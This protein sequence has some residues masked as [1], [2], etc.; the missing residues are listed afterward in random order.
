MP[1]HLA[2]LSPFSMP[3]A[4]LADLYLVKLVKEL[5]GFK[6]PEAVALAREM[7][8]SHDGPESLVAL[9]E[10]LIADEQHQEAFDEYRAEVGMNGEGN[11]PSRPCPL[12]GEPVASNY[13]AC[14]GYQVTTCSIDCMRRHRR[15]KVSE[16]CLP[17][18]SLLTEY[19]KSVVACFV[20]HAS[21]KDL[22]G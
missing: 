2:H 19:Q 1:K 18:T 11:A 9:S 20:K 4:V 5:S 16:K 12:C 22:A 8:A 6:P 15:A 21:T 17:K 14:P 13:E 10:A 3:T 7:V